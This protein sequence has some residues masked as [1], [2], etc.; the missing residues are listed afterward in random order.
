M[1]IVPG[2]LKILA[3]KSLCISSVSASHLYNWGSPPPS[4]SRSDQ[5]GG[6]EQWLTRP[7]WMVGRGAGWG[8]GGIWVKGAAYLILV[9]SF[10]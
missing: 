10:A 6:L 1:S 5:T 9:I 2:Q 7:T 4:S 8:W 3:V